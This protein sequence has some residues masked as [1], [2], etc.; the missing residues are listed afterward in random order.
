MEG[1]DFRGLNFILYNDEK[2]QILESAPMTGE[3]SSFL[4]FQESV[5]KSRPEVGKIC[6]EVLESSPGQPIAIENER[7]YFQALNEITG[8]GLILL[9]QKRSQS[10]GPWH[11]KRCQSKNQITNVQCSLCG[12]KRVN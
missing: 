8:Q 10:I 3:Y 1:N 4:A 6:Y 11:C 9:S 5:S 2:S 7:N 12:F